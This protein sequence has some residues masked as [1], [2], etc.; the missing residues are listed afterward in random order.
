MAL[1]HQGLMHSLLSLSGSHLINTETEPT[2]LMIERA[3]HHFGAGVKSLREDA[4]LGSRL[5]GDSSTPLE[6]TVV[7]QAV[8][9][10]LKTICVGNTS[11][12]YRYHL[13]AVEEM[14]KGHVVKNE[15]FSQFL[16]D[17]I[18]YHDM[19][20]SI[21]SERPSM[22]MSDDF[23]VPSFINPEAG[24]FLGV[25]DGLFGSISKIRR[26][27]DRIRRR[28]A[29]GAMPQVDF[30]T[31]LD[32]KAIDWELNQRECSYSSN[33]PQ[34]TCWQLY[35][36]C[37][38]LYLHR[39]VN[40]SMPNDQLQLGVDVAVGYLQSIPPDSGVQSVLLTPIFIVGCSAFHLNQRHAVLKAFAVLQKYS[41]L[42]NIKPARE[43]VEKIWEFMDA[44]D[45]STWD[46]ES[47]MKRMVSCSQIVPTL[48]IAADV[49]AQGYDL[50]IT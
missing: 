16:Y 20:S 13:D 15:N 5:A 23:V 14:L 10:C 50:L 1:S 36:S 26:L 6:E 45:E 22:M 38:W 30:H 19:S 34:W 9:L 24:V 42:G 44:G 40:P 35:R 21:T 31:I 3:K 7:A 8:F 39:T 18:I 11:G 43:V 32:A 46:W 33:T 4:S 49:S 37:S 17:F 27:R 25:C 29:T 28:R 48:E 47:I 41:A 12:E 2:S